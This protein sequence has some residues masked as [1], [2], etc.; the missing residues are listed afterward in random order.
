MHFFFLFHLLLLSLILFFF[1]SEIFLSVLSFCLFILL[2]GFSRQEYSSGLPFLSPVDH[3]LS[4]LSPWPA[5]LGWPNMA[6]LSFIELDKSVVRVIRLTSF[7]WLWFVCLPSDAFHNTYHLTW[8]SLT[9]VWGISSWLL[10]Q[11]AAAAPYLGRGL[12][13]HSCPSWPWTWAKRNND[14]FSNGFL[15]KAISFCSFSHICCCSVTKSCPTLQPH[16]LQHARL[17]YPSLCPRVFSDSCPLSW[18][19]YLTILS[20]A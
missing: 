16:G 14:N 13:P 19:C 17:P 12:S 4:D 8:V 7:L 5:C 6:S 18:W 15:L 10:Q 11:S 1:F 9:L 2:M 20:S 3:I